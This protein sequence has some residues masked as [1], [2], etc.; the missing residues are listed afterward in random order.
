MSEPKWLSLPTENFPTWKRVEI[1][2]CEHVQE[3]L[4]SASGSVFMRCVKCGQ[5]WYPAN[6]EAWA[7]IEE[8]ERWLE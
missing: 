1:R 2:E 7:R 6:S 8:R 3:F 5:E 4:D